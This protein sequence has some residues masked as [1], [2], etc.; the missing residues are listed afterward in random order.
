MNR[1]KIIAA[2][3]LATASLSQAQPEPP[4]PPRTPQAFLFQGGSSSYLG[5]GVSEID[6]E[7]A[8]ALKL[9]E[10]RGVEVTSVNNDGPASKA[11]LKVGDVVLEYNGQRVEGIE[12][13][14]RFVQETPV[15]RSV[16]LLIS[17]NGAMQTMTATIASRG[18]APFF[19]LNGDG[20]EG[21]KNIPMPDMPRP[22]M[23]TQS[24]M[25][26]VE[27]ES[28]GSQLAEYF[29]VKE[30]VLVRSVIRGSAAEKAGIKAGDVIT[31]VGDRKVASPGEITSAL[32]AASGGNVPVTLMRN[33]KEMTVTV[34]IESRTGEQMRK[35]LVRYDGKVL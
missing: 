33:Q 2:C 19:S 16:K 20:W 21:F 29:G 31:K 8:K 34:A 28:L 32:R 23:S 9:K 35:S 24:R 14:R 10:E 18:A 27:S 17:R 5:V 1:L 30:G 6:A 12:Q 26:G 15:G 22:L 11:G 25:L 4:R 3:A 7:R 13:F